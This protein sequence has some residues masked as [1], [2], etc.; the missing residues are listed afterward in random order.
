MRTRRS[1]RFRK[2][3]FLAVAAATT[4][5]LA[6]GAHAARNE[7]AAA[8]AWPW[9]KQQKIRF[10]WGCWFPAG[11]EMPREIIRCAALA[12]GTVFAENR[13]YVPANARV[14]KEFGMRYFPG[15][16]ARYLMWQKSGRAWV[17]EDGEREMRGDLYFKCPLDESVYERW[18][19]SPYLAGVR[20]G[21][22]DGIHIDWENPGYVLKPCY[23]DDCFSKFLALKGIKTDMPESAK[24]LQ[25]VKERGLLQAY[26]DSI[27]E[28]QVAMFRRV[29]GKLRA[30][31]PDFLFSSYAS[32]HTNFTQAMNA[33]D[34]PFIFL[35]DRHYYN[36]D[37]QAWWES[38]SQRLR[39]AGYL[40]ICGGWVNALFGPQASQVSA[41]QW[42]Y[43]TSVNE[44]GVWLWF[45]H[46]LTDDMMRAY[47]AADRRIRV[48]QDRVGEYLFHGRRDANFVTAL[49][50]TG[51]PELERAVIHHTYHLE[52]RHLVH[53]SNVHTDW[54]LRVRIRFPRLPANRQWTVRDPMGAQHYTRDG[55]AAIWTTADLLAGVVVA[56][57]TRSDLFLLVSPA[58]MNLNVD[59]SRLMYSREFGLNPGHEAAAAQA[60]AMKAKLFSLPKDGWLF[61]MDEKDAGVR[62]KWFLPGASL[63]GWIPIEIETFWGEK[64]GEGA[65][66]YRGDV[67]IPALPAAKPIY[68]HFGAV[69]E[70]LMLWID[71]DF[72]G[73]HRDPRGPAYSWDKPFSLDVTG[74]L[75]PGKHHLAMRVHNSKAAGG[76]WQ[77]VSIMDRAE[78]AVA[79]GV[80]SAAA[81]TAG[82]L[83][84][85]ATERI[86]TEQMLFPG[87]CGVDALIANTIRT[88]GGDGSNQLRVRQLHG[89]LWSPQYSPDGRQIAFVHQ[90]GGR[91]QIFVMNVDGTGAVNISRN[92]FSDRSPVWSPDGSKIAFVSDREGDWDIHVMNADGGGQRRLAGNAGLDRA[93]AWSPDGR[94]IAWESHVSG[95]PNIWICDA[96]GRNSRPLVVSDKP[97][98]LQEVRA[99]AD[100]AIEDVE[101]M[102]PDNTFYLMAP[103][104]SPDGKC[105]A[106]VELGAHPGRK[107]VVLELD[108]SRLLRLTSMPFVGDLCWSPDGK[109]LAGTWRCAPGETERSGIFVIKSDGT[110][111]R[112]YGN[113]LVNVLPQGPRLAGV[114]RRGL[115]TWYSHGSAQP[116]RVMKSFSSLA[117]SPDGRKLA[118]SSDLD[119]TGGFYVYTVSPDGGDPQRLDQTKSAWPNEIR[120]RPQKPE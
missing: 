45:E 57:E 99:G 76:I 61:K 62:G 10:M 111:G 56:L 79:T 22:I 13:A 51:R 29:A 105:M 4:A 87:S 110:D 89:Y 120:W 24:R 44:D 81:G 49:E 85:T 82:R 15:L 66:W 64:G 37:R 69:D 59:P 88:I 70:E 36:D 12:G 21:I 106:A 109:R 108:G 101:P 11:K 47:S 100:V 28:Q 41:E 104:W 95:M 58:D 74:K 63:N 19:V 65:G 27:R 38:Y 14:V 9:W 8:Q 17:R 94:Q 102:F 39:Q 117:W 16:E 83:V 30:V 97:L 35:D 50:W 54:P 80:Q 2:Q 77:Q 90:A 67:T 5:L 34:T 42:I 86:A 73:E 118:F 7:R 84:Y 60:G 31:N 119:P 92:D 113:W 48:V 71:G 107:A 33:P 1:R 112:P 26:E 32:G 68:L 116:R 23:C 75:T 25:F 40:Y 98:R 6:D 78:A 91:G 43:E 115:M 18:L 55:K 52:D 93:P 96:D 3:F 46:E 72:A 53:I 114:L 20:E 103:L